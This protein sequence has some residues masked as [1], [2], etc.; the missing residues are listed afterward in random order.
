MHLITGI[1]SHPLYRWEERG[2]GYYPEFVIS[3]P[4]CIPQQASLKIVEIITVVYFIHTYTYIY[5]LYIYIIQSLSAAESCIRD[6][7]L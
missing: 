4:G 6:L 2:F 3:Q 1:F 7:S 5:V